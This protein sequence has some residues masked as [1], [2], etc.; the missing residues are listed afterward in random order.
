MLCAPPSAT[1]FTTQPGKPGG[2]FLRRTG[3]C[4]HLLSPV[5]SRPCALRGK[6][7]GLFQSFSVHGCGGCGVVWGGR[8][9]VVKGSA[10]KPGGVGGECERRVGCSSLVE[11]G[12]GRNVR[13]TG[14]AR[15]PR[16]AL[17]THAPQRII[18]ANRN[19]QKNDLNPTRQCRVPQHH[20]I[21]ARLRVRPLLDECH[22][23][24]KPDK[25]SQI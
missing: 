11:N 7:T 18:S 20:G 23:P 1:S 22:H 12:R 9:A 3:A 5:P 2:Q 21:Q 25:P 13:Y 14:R 17:S 8:H 4:R 19:S 16:E 6:T 15:M 10:G 24:L